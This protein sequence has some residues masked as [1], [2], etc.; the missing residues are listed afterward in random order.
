MPLLP[1]SSLQSLVRVLV[2]SPVRFR[3]NLVPVCRAH[4]HIRTVLV[5]LIPLLC[6]GRSSYRRAYLCAC[7]K[8]FEHKTNQKDDNSNWRLSYVSF[9]RFSSGDLLHG[10]FVSN[11][12]LWCAQVKKNSLTDL[13]QL[14]LNSSHERTQPTDVEKSVHKNN[15][16]KFETCS[17]FSVPRLAFARIFQNSKM[18][19]R[20]R[21]KYEILTRQ[22]ANNVC[23]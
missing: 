5:M 13:I 3:C 16:H 7:I 21:P 4:I 2:R 6:S 10:R 11:N 20:P 17:E 15:V 1:R 23:S 19:T 8:P 9:W 14:L 22:C 12:V 18:L